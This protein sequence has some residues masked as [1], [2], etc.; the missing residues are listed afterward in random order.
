MPV[1]LK[2]LEKFRTHAGKKC[3]LRRMVHVLLCVSFVLCVVFVFALFYT[4]NTMPKRKTLV[5]DDFSSEPN[6]TE[7]TKNLKFHIGSDCAFLVET[8]VRDARMEVS[9]KDEHFPIEDV[10]VQLLHG[11]EIFQ[12]KQNFTEEEDLE[13]IQLTNRK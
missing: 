10:Q 11:A 2:H 1:L 8:V 5:L 6:S 7:K 13:G 9:S 3:K 4:D 12:E